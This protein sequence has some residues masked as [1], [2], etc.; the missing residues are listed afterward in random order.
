MVKGVSAHTNKQRSSFKKS[1]KKITEFKLR[2]SLDKRKSD[3]PACLRLTFDL[4]F[5]IRGRGNIQGPVVQS[6]ISTNSGLNFN[7]LFWFMHFC[8][9]VRFK[10]LN[11]KS[12]IEPENICGKTC[13]TS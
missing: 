5:S 7:L 2:N 11:N 8:S 10:S 6:T 1:V 3:T 13:S 12:F 4:K 9:T